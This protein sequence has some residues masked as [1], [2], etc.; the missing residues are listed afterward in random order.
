MPR[1]GAAVSTE[2]PRPRQQHLRFQTWWPRPLSSRKLEDLG[3]GCLEFPFISPT[4]GRYWDLRRSLGQLRAWCLSRGVPC[5]WPSPGGTD[6]GLN[7]FI[8]K[9]EGA[10]TCRSTACT[11]RLPSACRPTGIRGEPK[12]ANDAEGRTQQAVL[13]GS[14]SI[15]NKRKEEG[16]EEGKEGRKEKRKGGREGR[17]KEEEKERKKSDFPLPTPAG[18]FLSA[19]LLS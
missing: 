18:A 3:S 6:S 13:C 2:L 15:Q 12:G 19:L 17:K 10:G 9:G 11:V 14:R 8:G 5:G 1:A 7:A 4:P 16:R